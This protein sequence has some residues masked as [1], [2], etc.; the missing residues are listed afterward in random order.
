MQSKDQ[1]GG[2]AKFLFDLGFS[3]KQ[4]LLESGNGSTLSYLI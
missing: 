2:I 1:K 3:S 4:G